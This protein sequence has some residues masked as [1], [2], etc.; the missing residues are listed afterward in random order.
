MFIA[1]NTR[2][3][4]M[5]L[6]AKSLVVLN[7]ILI[8]LFSIPSWGAY[9]VTTTG[10]DADGDGSPASPWATITKALSAVP[11]GAEI[12]VQAGTYTGRVRLSGNFSQGVTVRAEPSYQVKLRNDGPVM[13]SY[14]SN[15]RGITIEGFDMAH[16]G[17]G[18]DALLVH[19][20]G[21]GSGQVSR[22]MLKNNIF[23]DSYNNDLVKINNGISDITVSGNIFYNQNG[24]DE[25]M[26]IN[27]AKSIV[28]T[29]N[30]FFNDFEGS[31]RLN[32]N[33]TSSFIVIKD[34]NGSSDLY[35]GS[36]N[37]QVRSNIF[38]GWQ[39]SSGS[40]F[41]L[42]GEDGQ[43]FFEGV[44][45]IIENNLMLGNSAEVMR[46]PFGV[47]GGK[48]IIFRFN[49]ISGDLPSLAYGMRFNRE[50]G[51][52]A[53]DNIELY[54]NI[55]SDAT[56]SMGSTGSGANDFSDTPPGDTVSFSLSGN[57]YWNGG[58]TIPYDN[59]ELINYTGDSAR[60]VADPGLQPPVD[61]ILPR[62]QPSQGS[63]ASGHTTIAQAFSALGS[64]YCVLSIT[65]PAVDS[66][67]SAAVPARDLLDKP[68]ISGTAA[69]RGACEY[70]YGPNS[71][72]GESS[73]TPMLFLLTR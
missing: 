12:V 47:K 56:G 27:S 30:I 1:G 3:M 40:N 54:G 2:G 19:L 61:V 35:T 39:G 33:D 50:G 26:D 31:G 64:S 15:I 43:T 52:P 44:D 72:G 66:A 4:L 24:S 65:S 9:H 48:N 69:D 46:A 6:F 41:V 25:H 63:F 59:G 57:L 8:L 16:S 71:G 17:P 55:W 11:D 18:S 32:R 42:V 20:D 67:L 58:N 62:W 23:H 68:R 34:S 51:N 14:G 53:N 13:T 37:V 29:R 38:L 28:I 10:S 21:G 22:I 7:P 70:Q 73:M 45:I 36:R 49:T 5:S 60:T